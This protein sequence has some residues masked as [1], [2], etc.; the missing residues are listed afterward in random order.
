MRYQNIG[1]SGEF[2]AGLTEFVPH[3]NNAEKKWINFHASKL[4]AGTLVPVVFK[5][6]EAP[7]TSSIYEAVVSQ[8]KHKSGDRSTLDHWEVK[9]Y[10]VDKPVENDFYFLAFNFGQ[11]IVFEKDNKPTN[12]LVVRFKGVEQKGLFFPMPIGK[13]PV[14]EIKNLTLQVIQDVPVVIRIEG[15]KSRLLRGERIEIPGRERNSNIVVY[16]HRTKDSQ[17]AQC[18][19]EKKIVDGSREF[20]YYKLHDLVD[21]GQGVSH[22][23]TSDG[24]SSVDEVLL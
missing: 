1:L 23:L 6:R 24:I 3:N 4:C 20:E 10:T 7:D 5:F 16:D 12:E 21:N 2:I 9:F 8:K 17:V 22:I 15:V 19:H 13:L 18:C 14:Y 11:E